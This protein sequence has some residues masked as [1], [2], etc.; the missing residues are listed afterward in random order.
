MG[1]FGEKKKKNGPHKIQSFPKIKKK[2]KKIQSDIYDN[3]KT[4]TLSYYK[5]H[6]SL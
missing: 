4:N 1:T 6:G 3:P 2:K 5:S